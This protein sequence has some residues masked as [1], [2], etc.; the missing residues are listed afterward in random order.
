MAPNRAVASNTREKSS[1]FCDTCVG[2]AGSFW[3]QTPAPAVPRYLQREAPAARVQ[4]ATVF[5]ERRPIYR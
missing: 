1:A 2:K 4:P 5:A 3:L